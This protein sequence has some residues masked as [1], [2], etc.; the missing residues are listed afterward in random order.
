MRD[1]AFVHGKQRKADK[2]F[3]FFFVLFGLS[4]MYGFPSRMKSL[5]VGGAPLPCV[6]APSGRPIKQKKPLQMFFSLKKRL[7]RLL[8]NCF[9]V[10]VH[11]LQSQK[12]MNRL[13]T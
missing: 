4:T 5:A 1:L 13:M 9:S 7:E 10:N 6:V 3:S 2:I 11:I 12:D 8:N